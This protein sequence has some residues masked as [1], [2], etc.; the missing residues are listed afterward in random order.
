MAIAEYVELSGLEKASVLLMALGANKS[1]EV[2]K[3]LNEGEIE[4]LS[5]EIVQ[6]R[7]TD[8]LKMKTVMAEFEH[9]CFIGGGSE[10]DGKDFAAKVL[11]QAMGEERAGEVLK[12]AVRSGSSRPFAF[13]QHTDAISIARILAQEPAQVIALVLRNLSPDKA[14]GVL[15]LMS[16]GQQAD[17]ALC[18]CSTVEIEPEIVAAIEEA[19]QAKYISVSRQRQMPD[20]REVLV[21]ILNRSGRSTEKALLDALRSHDPSVGEQVRNMLFVFEDF[22][23]LDDRAMR[24]VLRQLDQADLCLALKGAADSMKDRFFVNMTERAVENAKQE[25]ELMGPVRVRDIEMAQ[26]K[27]VSIARQ[28]IDLGQIAICDPDEELIS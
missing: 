19:L 12:K 5:G 24:L 2:F 10:T 25:L 20:G 26:Q 9:L 11:G 18:I 6:M 8:P 17:V 23:K 22:S 3:H 28:L 27:I 16:E 1:A 14:A 4:K 15:G 13:L 21:Q 7:E